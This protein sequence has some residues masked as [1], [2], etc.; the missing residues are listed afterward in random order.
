MTT[1]STHVLDSV[2]GLPAAD[3][4]VTLTGEGEGEVLAATTN[5]DGRISFDSDL[6]PG[7]H[8]LHFATGPWCTEAERDTFFPEVSV[9]FEVEAEQ[10]HVHVALLLGPYS[11]TTYRGS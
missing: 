9:T 10:E 4:S 3:L 2:L 1:L 5:V 6:P 7:A 11:Y 8:T